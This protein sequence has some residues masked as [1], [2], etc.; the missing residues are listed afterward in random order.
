MAAEGTAKNS[1]SIVTQ[2]GTATTFWSIGRAE[3]KQ[4]AKKESNKQQKKKRKRKAEG[5]HWL[6][7]NCHQQYP[8][9]MNYM[10]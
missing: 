1:D 8:F 6:C 3:T 7:G 4:Q 9:E 10:Y 2:E 5:N